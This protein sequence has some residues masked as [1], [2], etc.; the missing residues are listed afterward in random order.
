MLQNN[1]P[2]TA[3]VGQEKM[4]LA[5]ILNA[6]NPSIGGVLIRGEKGTGKT[7]AVRALARLLP[8][9]SAVAGCPFPF[10]TADVPND[11][12]PHAATATEKRPAPLVNLPLG[13]TEDRLLGTIDLEAALQRGERRFE[14]GLLAQAH[15]GILYIDEVNLLSDHIVDVLLDAAAMGV[16]IVEREG[17]SVSHPARFILV[18]TMNPEE[19]DLRPQLLDRFGLAVEVAGSQERAERAEIVRRRL[20]YE[21]NPESFGRKF[22]IEEEGLRRQITAAMGRLEQVTL[23]DAMLDLIA[24]I[25]LV[26]A[27]DGMRGDLTIYKTARTLAAWEGDAAVNAGHVQRAAE[28]ALLHRRRRQPFE[29]PQ[30]DGERLEQVIKEW[31]QGSKSGREPESAGDDLEGD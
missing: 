16:N 8:Q 22:A 6:I 17:V 30:L 24:E 19:G 28:L 12:W 9:I 5:L 15:G 3:I 23:D 26:F 4:R 25:C 1:Y 11:L 29:Q 7:T 27:V 13:V 2:F 10:G 14:A 18:G 20:K 31:E 21:A